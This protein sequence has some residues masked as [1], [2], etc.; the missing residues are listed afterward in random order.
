MSLSRKFL[1]TLGIESE[2]VDEII[3]AH[4]DTVN[5]LKGKIDELESEVDTLKSDAEKSEAV[6]KELDDLKKQIAADAK[7]REGK[8]YDALLEEFNNY[9]AEQK[10]KEL[11]GQK[12]EA[13]KKLLS[14]MNMSQKGVD[15]IMKWQGVESVELDDDGKLSN[16]KELRKSVKEDWGEY[17]IKDGQKGA[18]VDEPPIDNGGSGSRYSGM[19]KEEIMKI[20]D[21]TERQRA[22]SENHELFGY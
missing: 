13:F 19:S 11:D 22:I 3:S 16:A 14:D 2:K 4:S 8:D 17:L 5:A 7:K 15:M 6:Q 10:K 20:S 1:S 21:T 9:K 18:E 12:R